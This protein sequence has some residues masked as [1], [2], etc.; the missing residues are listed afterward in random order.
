MTDHYGG[1]DP[2]GGCGL[3]AAAFIGALLVF[4]VVVGRHLG[5]W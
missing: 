4:V 3:M 5:W 2:E 1:R